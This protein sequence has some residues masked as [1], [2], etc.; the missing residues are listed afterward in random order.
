MVNLHSEAPDGPRFQDVGVRGDIF[1]HII[2]TEI[3]TKGLR[4]TKGFSNVNRGT[5]VLC[6]FRFQRIFVGD[7]VNPNS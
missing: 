2:H 5:V 1:E 3:S 4:L 7:T 6:E